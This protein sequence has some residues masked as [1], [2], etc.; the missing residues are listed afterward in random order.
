[1]YVFLNHGIRVL[2]I[3]PH[4]VRLGVTFAARLA[5]R[6]AIWAR[7]ERRA[8][9]DAHA[10]RMRRQLGGVR[11]VTRAHPSR[12]GQVPVAGVGRAGN[13]VF[14]PGSAL[15]R[16]LFVPPCVYSDLEVIA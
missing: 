13:A 1:M 14:A 11:D 6:C 15:L 8:G 7:A 3:L 12:T 5:E 16:F 10:K 4:A 9:A 2:A